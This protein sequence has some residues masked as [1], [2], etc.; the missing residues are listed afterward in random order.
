MTTFKLSIGRLDPIHGNAPDAECT[1]GVQQRLN[2]LGFDAGAVDGICGPRTRSAIKRFQDKFKIDENKA[3]PNDNG[4]MKPYAGSQTL[5][6]LLKYHDRP[7]PFPAKP[8]D[9]SGPDKP[10]KSPTL[11][12]EQM[13]E[14]DPSGR[15]RARAL[16]QRSGKYWK[17]WA[18]RQA[19]ASTSLDELAEPFRTNAKAFVEKLKDAGAR[20]AVTLTRKSSQRAYLCHWAWQVAKGHCLATS[21]PAMEGVDIDWIHIDEKGNFSDEK[22]R[23]GAQEMVDAFLI[24]SMRSPPPLND[25]HIRGLA[26]EMSP[27][28]NGDLVIK[29]QDGT[30]VTIKT[31][32][33]NGNN[34]ELHQ[35]A[36]TYKVYRNMSD[37]SNQWYHGT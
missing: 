23:K 25:H 4:K 24:G 26:M 19:A 7:S 31:E 18:D 28:W 32:P 17:A 12:N 21:V 3:D 16:K 34:A 30:D 37:G 15:D 10:A 33:K 29:K 35:V 6:A 13:T 11:A 9:V 27:S 8:E 22:S 14:P 2:N 5:A 36:R 1:A 20:A